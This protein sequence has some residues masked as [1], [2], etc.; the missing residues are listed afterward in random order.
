MFGSEEKTA[1]GHTAYRLGVSVLSRTGVYTPRGLPIRMLSA[2]LSPSGSSPIAE[3]CC[4][5]IETKILDDPEASELADA[6]CSCCEETVA[7]FCY[8]CRFLGCCSHCVKHY[9]ERGSKHSVY[10][11]LYDKKLCCL[12][13]TAPDKRG[14]GRVLKDGLSDFIDSI[15]RLALSPSTKTAE[16]WKPSGLKNAGNTC[17]LN[18]TLQALATSA[19]LI[20]FIEDCSGQVAGTLCKVLKQICGGS[21]SAAEFIRVFSAT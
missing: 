16:K 21:A 12:R 5:H 11:D 17:F 18:A 19:M 6:K 7:G 9:Q 8:R 10:W 20:S 13:C 2:P 15:S 4:K 14:F 3:K 1:N